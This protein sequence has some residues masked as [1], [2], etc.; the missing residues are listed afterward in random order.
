MTIFKMDESTIGYGEVM[1]SSDGSRRVF[2]LKT[3]T[4]E[5]TLSSTLKLFTPHEIWDMCYLKVADGTPCLFLCIPHDRRIMAV[6][7]IGGRTR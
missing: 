5:L 1:P 2:V 4:Q 3:D 6:E 7:M